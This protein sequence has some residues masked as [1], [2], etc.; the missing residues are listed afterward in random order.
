MTTR[1][2]PRKSHDR[3]LLEAADLLAQA[4]RLVRRLQRASSH[5]AINP[6]DEREREYL[7][8]R[9]RGLVGGLTERDIRQMLAPKK[10][11]TQASLRL[12]VEHGVSV[13]IAV[14]MVL[15]NP[16]TKRVDR[17]RAEA[18]RGAVRRELPLA[19]QRYAEEQKRRVQFASRTTVEHI[20]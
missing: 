19:R 2:R 1:G 17:D 7:L 20:A 12:I 10:S 8:R 4:G 13:R 14:D 3:A 18:L 15:R 6:R 16:T 11:L 9:R 5:K